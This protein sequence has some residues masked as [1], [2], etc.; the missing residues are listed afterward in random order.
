M[1][2]R[3]ISA[4]KFTTR[5]GFKQYDVILTKAQSVLA[6]IISSFEGENIQTQYN[7]L[8]YRID[9]YFYEYN[10][11]IEIDENGH[12]DRNI[13]YEIKRQ[14]AIEQELGCKFIRTDPDKEDLLMKY[15]D[16]L[17]NQ[18]KKL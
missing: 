7:V 2:C 3:T 14:K 11:E 10:L 9:L 18:L 13:D 12:S 4:H 16:I 6:R 15:L 8:G 1:D 17:N 5:L